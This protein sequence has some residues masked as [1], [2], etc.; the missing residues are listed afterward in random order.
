MSDPLDQDRTGKI[1]KGK[2]SP[3][4]ARVPVIAGDLR[5]GGGRRRGSDDPWTTARPQRGSA[6]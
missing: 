2:S 4:E 6:H 5:T 1:K 3:V